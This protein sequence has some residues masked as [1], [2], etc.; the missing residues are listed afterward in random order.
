[1]SQ[2]ITI[3]VAVDVQGALAAKTLQDNIYLYDNLRT[4]GSEGNGTGHLITAINGSHWYNGSQASEGLL[5]WLAYSIS[6]TPPTLPRTL[7]VQ[8]AKKS[9]QKSEKEVAEAIH[10][11]ASIEQKASNNTLETNHI[12][13]LHHA[14]KKAKS[15]EGISTKIRKQDGTL[16][17]TGHKLTTMKGE[18]VQDYEKEKFNISNLMPII[19]NITGEAVDKE[20]LYLAQYG[21]PV[22]INDGWY[23]SATADTSKV[24]TYDYT[25]HLTLHQHSLVDGVLIWEPVQMTYDAQLKVTTAPMINGFTNAGTGILPM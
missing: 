25:L 7:P 1:M 5:N 17:D 8:T 2:E 24:G 21:T 15:L 12:T 14:I 19:S 6:S 4:E 16:V 22:L 11:M 9:T 20:I 3:I 23:W 18:L 10:K 13:Q